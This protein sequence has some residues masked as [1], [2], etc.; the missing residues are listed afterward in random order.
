MKNFIITLIVAFSLQL[1]SLSMAAGT[2]EEGMEELADAIVKNSLAHD[3]TSIAISSFPHTNGDQS[4]LSNYLSD[5]LVLKL[6]N[7]PESNIS[8]M[9]RSQ[10]N[11]I[12]QE[13]SF[14][15]SGVVDSKSIQQLGQL[16]GVDAL[17][18]GSITEMGESIRINARL[19]D[20][21]T[22]RVFSAAGCTIPKTSTTEEL[23]ARIIY[24][25][26][27]S[28]KSKKVKSNKKSFA[29]SSAPIA[30][31][32]RKQTGFTSYKIDL[33]QYE[34]GDLLEDFSANLIVTERKGQKFIQSLDSNGELIVSD[35]QLE[36]RFDL[37][38]GADWAEFTQ[39]I[40]LQSDDG[41]T[42]KVQFKG[43]YIIFGNTKT[44][45]SY[46]PWKG[47]DKINKCRLTIKGKMAKFFINDKF[48]GTVLISPDTVFSKLIMNG[49]KQNDYLTN[50]AVKNL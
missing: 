49:I 13:M 34:V 26:D 4:E 8:I 17:V 27:S 30:K 35:L 14:T 28:S 11:K 5:E 2:L 6:F 46:S 16:H 9:E 1:S 39:N 32:K 18:L 19:T 12:F 48:F 3:K 43:S 7:V 25:A 38:F 40:S 50:V 36:G 15:Q 42:I 44:N 22:G 45:R 31:K 29:G 37:T 47:G 41:Q 33:K 20:T 23:L 24:S 10:L 21:E